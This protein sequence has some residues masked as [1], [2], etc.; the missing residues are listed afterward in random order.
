M[1][2]ELKT[3][4]L[5]LRT[6]DSDY[7]KQVLEYYQFNKEHFINSMPKYHPNFFSLNYQIRLLNE[8]NKR[9]NQGVLFKIWIFKLSDPD[10]IIGDISLNHIIRGALQSCFLGYKL[11]Q[12]Y[13][14]NGYMTEA[15]ESIVHYA[16]NILQ[17]NR[18]EAN[19]MP[20][21]LASIRVVEKVGFNKEGYSPNYL[22]INGKWEGHF[23][24]A[25]LNPNN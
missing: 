3:K 19:I 15:V 10:Q 7:A 17:L 22:K 12:K 5:S 23:R 6:I 18:I 13:T 25:Y 8:Q 16:H 9:M 24:Y 2:L 11:D 21:N 1:H 14:A 4:R 20:S